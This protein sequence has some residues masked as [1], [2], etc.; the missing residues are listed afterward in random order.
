M[1]H[2]S[3]L[4]P[5]S[6]RLALLRCSFRYKNS[7]FGLGLK[8]FFL[9]FL[10]FSFV[11]CRYYFH[12]TTLKKVDPNFADRFGQS[13]RPIGRHPGWWKV[14]PSMLIVPRLEPPPYS[15]N[16]HQSNLNYLGIRER[17]IEDVY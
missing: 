10:L 13:G 3:D 2:V 16:R 9:F 17:R 5:R 15:D 8:Y 6:R 1:A 12:E 7:P 14:P 11:G 4:S